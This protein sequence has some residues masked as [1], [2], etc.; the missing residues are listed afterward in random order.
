VRRCGRTLDQCAHP[1]CM[2]AIELDAV[3]EAIASLGVVLD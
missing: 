2:D 3:T 1:R